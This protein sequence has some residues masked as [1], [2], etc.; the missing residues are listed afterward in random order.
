MEKSIEISE[1]AKLQMELRGAEEHEVIK[2]IRSGTKESAKHGKFHTQ[3][4]FVFRKES[5]VNQKYYENKIVGVIFTDE[6]DKI[7]VVTVQWL[8]LF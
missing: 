5:P 2:A 3:F 7:V 6:P 1:H 8:T 4:E